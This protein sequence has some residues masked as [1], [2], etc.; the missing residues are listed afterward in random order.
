M[1]EFL[2][3]ELYTTSQKASKS[4]EIGHELYSDEMT[5]MLSGYDES[6]TIQPPNIAKDD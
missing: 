2:L 1:G 6:M 4:Y 3:P 5:E